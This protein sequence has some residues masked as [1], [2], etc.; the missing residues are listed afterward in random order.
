MNPVI[1]PRSNAFRNSSR[2]K[3]PS[4]SHSAARGRISLAANL[5]TISRSA[6]CSG[7]GSKSSMPS[8]LPGGRPGHAQPLQQE[9]AQLGGGHGR[10][11]LRFPREDIGEGQLVQRAED[12][13][14]RDADVQVGAEDPLLL[15]LLEDVADDLKVLEELHR[16]VVFQEFG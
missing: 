16:G 11:I 5:W 15:P 6:S 7:V 4:R 1:S 12:G 2:G 14:T 3:T 9:P 13:A 10:M 8:A